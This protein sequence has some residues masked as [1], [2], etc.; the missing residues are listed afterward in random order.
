M[1]S[2]AE[3]RKDIIDLRLKQA[4]WDVADRSQVIEEFFVS[5]SSVDDGPQSLSVQDQSATHAVREF[6]DFVL[7]GK[8]GKPIAV[9]EAK[10]SSKSAELGREQAKQYCHNIRARNDGE[11]PFCF[12]TNGHEIFFWNLGEAAP[13]KVH[14]FPTRQDFERLLYI[15]K[16]KKPL[17]DELIDTAIA[18]R[19]YQLQAIRSVMEGVA[20]GR[21]QFLLVMATGT[22]KT[23]T[24]IAL[25]DALMRASYVQRVLFLVDRIA[26]RGQALDTFKEHIPDEPRWPEPGEKAITTDRRIYVATYP[27]MLN[28]VRDEAS[29]LSPHFFDLVVIDESHRSIYNTY[30]EVLNYFNAIKLGLTATPRDVIDHNTFAVFNCE[31]GL[32]SFA[33]SYDEAISHIPPYLCDFSVLKIKTKFQDEGI[34]KRTISLEDQKNLILD[35]KDIEEI[36]F[37]GTDLEKTVTNHATN[38]LIVKEFMEESIKDSNGVLPGKT[39]FFCLSIEHA[40]RIERIFDSLYPEYRGELAKVMVSDDPRVYGKGGLLDQFTRNDMPRVAISVDMLDT[41][42]DV[43][44]IVNLVFAKPVFSYTKFWQMIGR[45]TRLLEKNK[46]KAWCPKK[47]VFQVIDCWDNFD[48]F[49][50]TPKGKE[51]KPQI[52]LPVRLVGIRIDKIEAAQVL[53]NASIADKEIAVLRVQVAALPVSSVTIMESRAKLARCESD[54]FWQ[55]FTADGLAFL[56]QVIQPLF[57]VVSQA[58]FK[59]MRFE[60]DVLEASLAQLKGERDKYAILTQNLTAQIS[61]LPL[62]VNVVAQEAGLIQ[63]AQ[64]NH[65]WATITDQGF[66]QLT[67][68]LSPLMHYRDGRRIGDGPARFNFADVLKSKEYV[69][70]GP[71]HESLSI[72]QYRQLVEQKVNELTAS[73][74]ILQKIRNGQPVSEEEAE[75]LATQLHD[76]HPHITLQLLR[77]VYHHQRAPFLRFIRHILGIEILESF[78]DTVSR[79]IDQFITEHPTLTSHQLQFLG[80]LRD[81]LIDR[82]GIEKRDLIQ[83]PFTVIHPSGIRGVFSPSEIDEILVLTQRLAA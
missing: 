29:F 15:R 52:P 76:E 68:R 75:A 3:T 51:P 19:D 37:E 13:Q 50:L 7:L 41:G 40:R 79:S 57:R 54:A 70:F 44:E 56:R 11:L 27:T 59:A 9:V 33:F 34:S 24:C 83:S 26:L 35:G 20:K 4:G 17:T 8:N 60:K 39:I 61:E 6:S 12:Y 74:P 53:G 45:G 5:G 63:K 71:E 77:R 32:P 64:T 67:E 43:R 78:P 23:R 80:L 46:I 2:E 55:R 48:Y 18:G 14:G 21:R 25:V 72:A 58:D 66:D 82:G 81:F 22:G 1:T 47:D 36:V 73:N 28:I 31:D 65:Y 38:A 69:E 62:S 16:H 30:G 10:K 42:I 49:R